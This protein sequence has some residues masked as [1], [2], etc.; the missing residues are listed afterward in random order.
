MSKTEKT[1]T[2]DVQGN[3]EKELGNLIK[4]GYGIYFVR[5]ATTGGDMGLYITPQGH[6]LIRRLLGSN[7]RL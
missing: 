4:E 2:I 3:L 1:L 5:S 6:N 7:W